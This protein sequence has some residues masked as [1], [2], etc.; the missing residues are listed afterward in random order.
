MNVLIDDDGSAC[1]SDFGLSVMTA[2]LC[3]LSYLSSRLGGAVHWAAP[4]IFPVSEDD[5]DGDDDEGKPQLSEHSDIYSYGCIMFEVSLGLM[6]CQSL[7]LRPR[8]QTGHDGQITLEK[9]EATYSD[10]ETQ[11]K[12]EAPSTASGGYAPIDRP[13]LGLHLHP[14]LGH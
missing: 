2:D 10:T 11:P 12:T 8:T 9:Y 1:L 14:V 6:S 4:E 5:G 7:Y 3:G 13:D